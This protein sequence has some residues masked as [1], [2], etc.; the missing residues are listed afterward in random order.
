MNA[1]Q[2]LSPRSM[3]GTSAADRR[4]WLLDYVRKHTWFVVK[5]RG[6]QKRFAEAFDVDRSVI[7]DDFRLIARECAVAD[8]GQ[9]EMDTRHLFNG[10]LA[11]AAKYAE[12]PS[13]PAAERARYNQQ[14]LIGAPRQAQILEAFGKKDRDMAP[15]P[16]K[17]ERADDKALDQMARDFAAGWKS[18]NRPPKPEGL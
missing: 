12:D 5:T 2:E 18:K 7:D 13:L 14:I 11:R 1:T 15:P 17:E 6:Q 8:V 4:A 16:Q 10:A 9:I 3:A